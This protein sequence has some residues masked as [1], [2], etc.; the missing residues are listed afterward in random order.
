MR[1]KDKVF[2]LTLAFIMAL[3]NVPAV[4]AENTASD[5]S[6]T[7]YFNQNFEE[8]STGTTKISGYSMAAQGN[9]AEV[10]EIEGNKAFKMELTDPNG[11]MHFNKTL[12]AA[13]EGNVVLEMRI[14]SPDYRAV[15]KGIW[16]ADSAG[17]WIEIYDG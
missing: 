6:T 16:A 8:Y 12:S 15:Q 5:N 1:L 17:A 14:S 3:S 13:A 2:S 7:V 11:D 9:V 10:V 4:L